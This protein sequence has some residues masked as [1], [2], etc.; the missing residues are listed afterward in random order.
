MRDQPIKY[1]AGRVRAYRA[2]GADPRLWRLVTPWVPNLALKQWATIVGTLLLE[3][4]IN[5]RIGAMYIEFANV[6][7][8]GDTVA[9]P[10]FDRTPAS[11]ISYYNGLST[12]S[13]KDY[14]R[15][16]ITAGILDTTDVANC[17]TGDTPSWFAMTQG[18]EGVH[19]KPFS[20]VNNST[21]YGAALV[22]TVDEADPTQDLVFSRFYLP[23]NQQLLKLATS[24]IGLQW[25]VPLQ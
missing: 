5:Y 19:G 22:A 16:P 13:N 18:V 11:A 4:R 24:Q 7:S 17:P 20:N 23:T 15:V 12:S 6:A 1:P 2:C 9:A 8:P 21:V 3:G 25:Q 14:L 10:T